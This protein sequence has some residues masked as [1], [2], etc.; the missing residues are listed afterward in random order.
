MKKIV[1]LVLGAFLVFTANGQTWKAQI[2]SRSGKPVTKTIKIK[3]GVDV[4][5]GN[6]L[7]TSDSLKF[8][9]FHY[10][11]F[12]SA[13][14]DSLKLR[15]TEVKESRT[16]SNGTKI[17]T[18]I[19][20]KAYLSSTYKNGDQ[21]NIAWSD[22][23]QLTYADRRKDIGEFFELGLVTSVAVLIVSPFLCINYQ[24]GTFNAERYKYWALGGT[25]GFVASLAVG[26]T[27]STKT[28]KYQF[29]TGWPNPNERTWKFR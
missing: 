16:L 1:T 24:D 23:Y 4:S 12:I 7:N 11:T 10:G 3:S 22:I 8:N 25:A 28:K 26:I 21:V 18:T 20:V 29:K 27:F 14:S 15:L 2:E 19:P 6:L 5:A 13:N 9:R 17:Q